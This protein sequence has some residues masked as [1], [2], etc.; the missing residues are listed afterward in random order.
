MKLSEVR[1]ATCAAHKCALDWKLVNQRDIIQEQSL[2]LF[3]ML[4]QDFCR[5]QRE[6]CLVSVKRLPGLVFSIFPFHHRLILKFYFRMI[7]AAIPEIVK[8]EEVH[9]YPGK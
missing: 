5:A 9:C 3:S 7:Q 1:H 2:I 6:F 8:V 4:S